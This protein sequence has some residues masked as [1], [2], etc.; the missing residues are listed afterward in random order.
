MNPYAVINGLIVRKD[1]A[2]KNPE[3]VKK[4]VKSSIE[5][6][7]WI[8]DH[9]D[10]AR[11]VIGKNLGISKSVYRNMRMFYF[12]RNGYQIMPSIWDFYYLMVKAGELQ[13]LPNLKSIMTKYW[14]EP[15]R[16]FIDPVL[17]EI[18][19][20]NDPVVKGLLKIKLPNLPGP[21][22]EYLAPWEN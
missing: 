7:R 5:A 17:A 20:Q 16:K 1:W 11:A 6:N 15:A 8:D 10:E 3:L 13:P 14:Y 18:G 4:L 19:R 2:D 22:S 12:P 9:P 21:M